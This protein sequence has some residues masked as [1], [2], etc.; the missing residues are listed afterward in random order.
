MGAAGSGRFLFFLG[1]VSHN[2]V[3]Q[4]FDFVIVGSGRIGGSNQ[5]EA[6]KKTGQKL[7]AAL[8]DVIGSVK[9]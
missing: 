8:R 7:P 4:R 6:A 5:I 1:W 3:M 9:I 2:C